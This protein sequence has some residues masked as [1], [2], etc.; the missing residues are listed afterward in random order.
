MI[1]DDG[2][3][4]AHLVRDRRAWPAPTRGCA[5]SGCSRNFGHQA[6]LSA[7]MAHARGSTVCFM[8][9]DL[10]DPP[11]LLRA[12][13]RAVAGGQRGRLRHPADPQGGRWS[14]GRPTAAFY[15]LYRRLA[16]IDVPLDSGDFALLD[17]RVV[18]ELLALPEHNRFLRGLRSWVGYRQVG[19]EYDRDARHAGE[20]KYTARRLFRLAFDGLL[21]FSAVP[22]AAGVVPRDPRRPRRRRL[23]RRWPSS[24]G[25]SSAACRR[26]GRRS[27]RSSSP[28]AACSSSSWAC[29]AST[30][31]AS[32]TSRR[33]GRTSSSPRPPAPPA[34]ERVA[35]GA[36]ALRGARRPRAATTGG[37]SAA[38]P[39]IEAVLDP[40]PAAGDRAGGSSTS[41]AAPAGCCPLLATL[42]RRAGHRGRAARR[43]ALPRHL[44]P[45]SRCSQGE[46]PADVP[47][48]GSLRPRHRLRRDRAHRRRP[49]RRWRPSA[50]RCARG[51]GRRH[52]ARAALAV[53]RPR[54]R[55]RPPAALRRGAGSLEVLDRAGLDG[56]ARR[57]PSTR[58]CSR[59]VAAARLAQRLRP[60]AGRAPTPTSRCP[61]PPSTPLLTRV[62][63]SERR[64]VA[65]PGLPMGVS[66]VVVARRGVAEP[67][68]SA[69][70]AVMLGRGVVPGHATPPRTSRTGHRAEPGH[71]PGLADRRCATVASA[72]VEPAILSGLSE[73]GAGSVSAAQRVAIV[74][75]CGHVGLPLGLAFADAGLD[76]VLYDIDD[77]AIDQVRAGKMPFFE[78]GRR[79]GARPGAG[80]PAASRS[81]PIPSSVAAVEHVVVV[82]GTPVDEHLNPDPGAVV[83]AI[84]R[85]ARP[86]PRRPA[87]RAA[88]HRLPR[89]SPPWSSGCSPGTARRID[90]AFCP[91]RIAEGKA[92]EELHSLPQIVSG[93]TPEAVERAAALFGA[94]HRADH[95]DRG[96]GGRAGQALHQHL[97]LHQVRGGQPALHDRH[98][99]RR[100]LR[101]HPR[102]H[103]PGLPA[104]RRHARARAWPPGP[105]LL[106]DTMQLAAFN[107]NNFML[108]HASMMVNEG[109][110]E[111]PRRPDREGATTCPTMT[112]GAARHGLQGRVRRHPLQPQLQA[113]APA[114]AQGRPGAVHRPLRHRRRRP[115]R[116]STQV[117]EQAD[118]LV[119]GAPH[120]AYAELAPDG[121]RAS[122]SGT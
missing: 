122:T 42:R 48:D 13:P 100:R 70:S 83:R 53:E 85:H 97:A 23:R 30:S 87:P 95:P 108:G 105:C 64:L 86:P 10:Q 54:R 74:G 46:I 39:I 9:A 18:D 63:A 22:A 20:P 79:R 114:Q 49:R 77:A 109:L 90:V 2:S 103:D 102:G 73:G 113:Q 12:A 96:G 67:S 120:R 66:L 65:G 36:D 93:R 28:S 8:D 27:S 26:A 29:W 72:G 31:P 88:Q 99:L 25:S 76:V 21:S 92:M 91:E 38:A 121:A 60:A 24:P 101:A 84:E 106:K 94:P 51:H 45:S 40:P 89:A 56:G 55:Q 19:V 80:Q 104:G 16:N 110:P 57:R 117:L 32:T 43:R 37:S 6:A 58:C 111:V 59:T 98:R 17:R 34:S 81:A 52:G 47:T 7:G 116:R 35:R 68:R 75:G 71:R 41:G 3:A 5:G 82:I 50:R 119:V 33:P 44:R 1:V 107:N 118:L 115:R 62:L 61:R 11:E 14:S 15:R 69:D 78:R 112:V 4:D